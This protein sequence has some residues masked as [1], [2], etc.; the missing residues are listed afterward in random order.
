MWY[1]FTSK[2]VRDKPPPYLTPPPMPHP[3]PLWRHSS[4]CTSNPYAMFAAAVTLGLVPSSCI[5]PTPTPN[6]SPPWHSSGAPG[7]IL[8]QDLPPEAARDL[9][10]KYDGH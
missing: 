4:R 5:S 1:S 2:T 7:R 8:R 10:G 6:P 3:L 9:R